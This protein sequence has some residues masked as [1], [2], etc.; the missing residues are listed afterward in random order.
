MIVAIDGPSGTGKGTVARLVARRLGWTYFDTGAMYRAFALFTLHQG[1]GLEDQEGLRRLLHAFDFRI[2]GGD[3]YFIGAE[4]VTHAIRSLEVTRLSS[5]ISTFP[6]VREAL[7]EK[8][9]EYGCR[10]NA[11]FEGRDI[12]TVVFPAADVKIFLTA[13]PEVRAQ[14]RHA[15]LLAKGMV[16]SFEEVFADMEERDR[17][18]STRAHSPLR[19]AEGSLLIDTSD[20]TIDEVVEAVEQAIIGA[21]A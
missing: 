20:M 1:V 17:S 16:V 8:Q 9:R 14:R 7:V 12:G 4:E 6:W 19:K 11:I 21:S 18:D 5:T 10:C 3:R 15:E 13:R 2:E